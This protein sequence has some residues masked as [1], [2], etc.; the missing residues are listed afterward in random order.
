MKRP[1][2]LLLLVLCSL[3]AFA[4]V[5]APSGDTTGATDGAAINSALST[6][7][8]AQ[9]A[10]NA[11]YYT[12]VSIQVVA[13]ASF[14]GCGTNTLITGVGSI[15]GGI[16]EILPAV[17]TD[18]IAAQLV[19]N[20]Q[21][22]GG[23]ATNAVLA[24]SRT[25]DNGPAILVHLFNIWVAGGHYTDV[26]WFNTFFNNEVDNIAAVGSTFSVSAS[27]FH[28]DGQVNANTFN[29]LL[30]DCGAPYGFYMENDNETSS[31]TG[32]TFNGL[33]A[34]G[35]C[36]SAGSSATCAGLYVG[37]SFQ[38]DTFNG[39]YTENVLHPLV[40]GNAASNKVCSGLTFNSPTFGGPATST[41]QVALVDIDDCG[42]VTFTSP[43]FGIYGL[44]RSAPLTFSGGGCSTEPTAVAIPNPSGII[45]AVTLTYPGAG[46]TSAPTIAVGGAGSGASITATEAGGV[47]TGLTIA[48]GGTGYTLSGIVPLVYNTINKAVLITAPTCNDGLN[49]YASP[50][51]PWIVR[52]SGGSGG[53]TINGDS[54]YAGSYFAT[55]SLQYT[56]NG[57]QNYA[58]YM[59]PAGSTILL[60]VVPQVY[61]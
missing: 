57:N 25:E 50:C 20:F 42:A 38:A 21:I 4:Q 1:L 34:E 51:W 37:T 24:G 12:N 28:F 2:I 56:G 22:T 27:C 58:T 43:A 23:T 36:P 48:A 14:T 41:N 9:L 45:K 11:H 39:F 53:V 29:T 5:I 46:C 3:P 8:S 47:V 61:P 60:G 33:T 44:A 31:S 55:G 18:T 35:G 19:G 40:L 59:N 16:V 6:H 17:V 30:A 13:S 7:L 15:T 52:S 26:F 54:I 49:A 10:C 32:N